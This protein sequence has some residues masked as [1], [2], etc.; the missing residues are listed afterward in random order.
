ML[1]SQSLRSAK[2]GLTIAAATLLG[3]CS[4][5]GMQSTS[6]SEADLQT[7]DSVI[8][9]R[10]EEKKARD[11]ER[12][13]KET[14]S[15]FGIEPGMKVAEVLPG[16]GWYTEILAPYIGPEGAL[17]GINYADD[18][19]SL[20]GFFNEEAI[21]GRIA[22]MEKFPE[23]VA[24]YAGQPI[25]SRGFAF[26]R[27]PEELKGQLD[28]VIMIRALHNLNRF[29]AKAGTRSTALK[30]V[31]A[32]L[33]T[34]GIV[35]VV[36]HLAPEANDDEWASGRAGYL[37]QSA[38]VAMFEEAGFELVATSDINI[39]PKDQPTTKD[40]VWRLAPS[41]RGPKDTKDARAAIGESTR[42][43][44]KFKKL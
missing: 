43:T 31:N 30:D 3:A 32:L 25:P 1:T 29:E 22:A 14:L 10:S 42:I 13:P 35:G 6:L 28:A 7:L 36:Q 5:L 18:M 27:I 40:V 9:S 16:R 8:A 12:N 4:Y 38:I 11:S 26:G 44:M 17:Y 39:N 23:T 21:K 37:K 24:A 41:L 20:F 2:I 34:G 15:F 33:K 19:W